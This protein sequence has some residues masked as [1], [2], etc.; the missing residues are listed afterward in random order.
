[1]NV[2]NLF[3]S[4]KLDKSDYEKNINEAKKEGEDFA[5]DTENK[6]SPKAVAGW[7]AIAAAVIAVSKAVIKLATESMNYADKVSDLAAQYGV[8]TDAISEMQYIAEQ[9]STSVEG[10]TSAMRMLYSRA[11]EDGEAFQQLGISVKD[12]N[13]NFKTMDEL[14][15][16]TTGALNSIENEGEKSAVM[17][18]LFG[19]S[20]M[21]VGEVLRK[22]TSEI[23]AMR[24]EAHDLGIVM[25][26]ETVKMA[27]D[28]NDKMAVM[29][30][31]GQSALASL[32]AGAPDAEERL[33]AFFD[34]VLIMLEKYIPAFVK[35]AVRLITQVAIALVK[36]A[37][38]LAI[39]IVNEIQNTIL[40]MDWFQFGIEI[41][42]SLINGVINI[43]LSGFRGLFKLFGVDIPTVDI[44]GDNHKNTTF[45]NLQRKEQNYE[46]QQKMK[47]EI[48]VK[49]EASGDT[50][51]SKESAEKTAEALAPYIDKI[52]GSR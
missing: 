36:I 52:L 45:E 34:N 29:K 33:Q 18:D 15:W 50:A 14:F 22:S 7:A 16:D 40:N 25:S 20:A 5:E 42:K 31:Q 43:F 6:I 11:K 23:N 28:F 35:F 12:T 30:M 37:P 21:S 47:Q 13:G 26:E 27:S 2:F 19:R 10:L 8:T 3:A 32:I 38:Q 1:M 39:D 9:S 41:G 17:L 51:V 48:T 44:F 4:L 24:Q 49:V 46:I